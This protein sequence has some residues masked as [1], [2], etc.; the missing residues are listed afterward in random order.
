MIPEIIIGMDGR[1]KNHLNAMFQVN[2]VIN[3]KV[4]KLLELSL[5]QKELSK[6]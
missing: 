6:Q 2:I 4:N 5:Y 1:G 3:K